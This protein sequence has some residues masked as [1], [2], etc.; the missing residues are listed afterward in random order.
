MS[1]TSSRGRARAQLR[2]SDNTERTNRH[3][4]KTTI[5]IMS[6]MMIIMLHV[7]NRHC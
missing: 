6:Q 3:K 1:V 7:V 5:Q 4:D 2:Q